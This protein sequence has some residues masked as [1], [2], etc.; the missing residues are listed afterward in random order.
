[1]K[2]VLLPV[3]TICLYSTYSSA[4]E[5]TINFYPNFNI[6]SINGN[7]VDLKEFSV[8]GNSVIFRDGK[9]DSYININN[10]TPKYIRYDNQSIDIFS[11]L[12]NHINETVSYKDKDYIIISAQNG[13]IVL[14]DNDD[15]INF[16]N[17]I[18]EIKFPSNWIDTGLKGVSAYFDKEIE[19]NDKV[20]WAQQEPGLDYNNEYVVNIKNDSKLDLIQYLK[21]N[22]KTDSIYKDV[23][24][25]FY[26]SDINVNNRP[27]VLYRAAL[28]EMKSADNSGN[29]NN[30]KMNESDNVKSISLNGKVNIYKNLNKL[31]YKEETLNYQSETIA[32]F[33]NLLN[34]YSYS[35]EINNMINNQNISKEEVLKQ[36]K[37]LLIEHFDLKDKI[38]FKDYIVIENKNN[39]YPAGE[40]AVYGKPI[41]DSVNLIVKD[42]ISYSENKDIKIFKKNNHDIKLN[43]FSIEVKQD[44][45]DKKY[46][47][48]FK[49]VTLENTSKIDFNVKI[50]GETIVLK[51]K[52]KFT[53][54]L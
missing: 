33:S 28:M 17:N 40:M 45:K 50:N 10:M 34:Q 25:N 19:L 3:L 54:N 51:A 44:V 9:E 1:M 11:L 21:V 26:F 24:V 53:F 18:E 43:D 32:D 27:P 52:Q 47:L 20:I 29:E 39:I 15:K 49:N 30:F 38:N 41:N 31:K 5:K 48:I 6:Y 16:V 42:S 8:K 13:N 37:R 7:L 46:I 2:K 23:N 4:V 22:N 12:S 36:I 14:K 35:D